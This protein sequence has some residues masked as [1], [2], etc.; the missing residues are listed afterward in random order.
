M[1]QSGFSFESDNKLEVFDYSEVDFFNENIEVNYD[2]YKK[3][4]NLPKTINP[5][6]QVKFIINKLFEL[7][8]LHIFVEDENGNESLELSKKFIM[9]K[10]KYHVT[11]QKNIM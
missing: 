7:N 3:H 11:N 5:N 8:M 1:Y 4:F 6:I 10:Y 9:D 2:L